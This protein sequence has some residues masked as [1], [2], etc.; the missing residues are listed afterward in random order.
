VAGS[1]RFGTQCRL[2]PSGPRTANGICRT[3]FGRGN[4][5]LFVV[6]RLRH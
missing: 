1:R 5:Y 4:F 3:T 2:G 6:G